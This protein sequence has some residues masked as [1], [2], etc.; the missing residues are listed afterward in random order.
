LSETQ[1]TSSG[2]SA[3]AGSAQA[4]AQPSTSDTARSAGRGGVA[5]L[6]AKA[7]F[8]LAGLL[9]QALLP[10]AIGLAGYGA[11]SRVLAAANIVNN[12]VVASATQGVSRAVAK[13]GDHHEEALRAALRVHAVIA[14]V[15]G[16][17]FFAAAPFVARFEG[18]DYIALPLRVAAGVVFC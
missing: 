5:V 18:A 7:F 13:A 4:S 3:S 1:A 12:V 17:L 16:G 11:L 6:G 9:Q 10:R 15:A 14:V 2:A 8:I